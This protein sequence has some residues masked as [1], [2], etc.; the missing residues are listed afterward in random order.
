MKLNPQ[1]FREYDIRGVPGTDYDEEFTEALGRAFASMLRERGITR[2]AVGR[3]C[4]LT[5]AAHAGAL[6]QG[7]RGGGIDVVDV[8]MCATPLLYYAVHLLDLSA[9]I[10]VTGSHNPADHNGFKIVVGK[11]TIHGEAIRD[12]ARRIGAASPTGAASPAAPPAGAASPA[13]SPAGAEGSE[14]DFAIAPAYCGFMAEHF[15]RLSRPLKVVVDS[16]NGTA[17]PVAPRIYRAMGCEVVELFSEPDGTF[18]NHHP[19]PT[20]EENLAD[21][22]R[23]VKETG[24]DLGLA[25][26]GDADRVG[27]VD[28]GGRVV[29][30]D[31][32]LV[33]FARDILAR[34]PG[35]AIVSEV[36]CSQRLFDDIEARG[37]RAIMWKAGHSLLKAKMRETG[38]LLGGEMSGHLFFADRYFG[39]DDGIYAGARMI[40]ILSRSGLGLGR[41]LADLPHTVYTPEI[42]VPCPDE[43]KFE[44]ASAAQERFREL[45]HSIVDVD[46][47]R[48]KFDHGWGLIRASNTQ[49]ILVLRFEATDEVSLARYRRLVEGELEVLRR[50]LAAR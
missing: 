31:E 13:A 5:S 44:L 20:V 26:D 24:A 41:M 29:W 11:A 23:K 7:I 22:R 36:K 42:R 18:P 16:G 6:K 28:S 33:L 8:G 48:V 12:L 1:I 47:V 34:R 17:G 50:R 43:Q 37:G 32:M 27:V 38:A 49:P 15:G 14:E 35:A 9:G 21:L 39:F 40:E 3:D 2:A 25:F 4:R 19:D 30:G 10:Q 45:G 46:G